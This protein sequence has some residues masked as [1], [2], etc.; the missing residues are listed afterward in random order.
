MNPSRAH[1]NPTDADRHA[2]RFVPSWLPGAEPP[3]GVNQ[4]QPGDLSFC[5]EETV[6]LPVPGVATSPHGKP[7]LTL[8]LWTI[9]LVLSA[10]AALLWLGDR[11]PGRMDPMGTENPSAGTPT[12][13]SAPAPQPSPARTTDQPRPMESMT[14]SEPTPAV[15]PEP[16]ETRTRPVTRPRRKKMRRRSTR[17]KEAASQPKTSAIITDNPY[18]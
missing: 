14:T 11:G 9:A 10:A 3:P 13:P 2:N 5:R 6:I 16:G 4:P 17:S 18:R 8:V 1:I 12:A 15:K 7:R